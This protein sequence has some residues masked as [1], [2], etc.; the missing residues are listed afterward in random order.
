MKIFF[1]GGSQTVEIGPQGQL[2][3]KNLF[4]QPQQ[5]GPPAG[6]PVGPPNTMHTLTSQ[7]RH[8][9]NPPMTP[10]TLDVSQSASIGASP[11]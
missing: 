10:V 5:L 7:S 4:P 1:S 6:M 11:A 9:M 2:V 3:P 8:R